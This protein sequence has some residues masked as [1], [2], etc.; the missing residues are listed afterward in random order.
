M[1]GLGRSGSMGEGGVGEVASL[2][3]KCE[4]VH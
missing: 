2:D 3:R 1:H 4:R